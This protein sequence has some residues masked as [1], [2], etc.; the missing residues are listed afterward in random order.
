VRVGDRIALP[1]SVLAKPTGAA[2]NLDCTYCFYLSK[3]LLYDHDSQ[4]MSE[5]DLHSYLE[6]LFDSQPDGPVEVAWQGGEPTLRGLAFFRRAVEL[7]EQLHRPG[8]HVRH[9]LQTNGTLLDDKWGAFLAEHDFLVG[10]S[11]DGPLDLHDTYRVNR[12]G[13]GSHTQV[14][15]G[16]QI[17]QRHGVEANIICTV[18]AANQHHPRE[19]Y[20]YFRDILGA[21]YLQFI[22]VVERVPA[23]QL[24]LAEAGWRSEPHGARTVLYQQHGNAVTSRSANPTAYGEFLV[25]IFDEWLTRDVGAV[26]VQDFDVM[27]A[28]LFGQH[29]LCV[30]SPEC[31]NAIAVEHNGDVYSCDHYVEPDHLLGNVVRESLAS[32]VSSSQQLKFG[33]SKRTSL[34]AQCQAC[35][36][37]WACHGGCPKDRFAT[38][39]DRDPQL[40]YLCGGYYAFFTHAQPAIEEMG[41]LLRFG[42]PASDIMG[43]APLGRRGSAVGLP[44]HVT[45]AR[46]MLWDSQVGVAGCRRRTQESQDG[47]WSGDQIGRMAHEIGDDEIL[48]LR[49]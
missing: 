11:M 46:R 5:S 34:P 40:N 12:A 35:P 14:L 49:P 3:E 28:N 33:R 18:H 9:T 47:A 42:R 21:R 2:C 8:Q 44:Q 48:E 16:W 30:H 27:L 43:D 23:E 17:L 32:L 24:S 45:L 7:A 10:L 20:R 13:R 29:S 36:V 6:N 4:L 26:F 31:G 15:R 19:V 25:E 41:R 38:T 22:P 37:R 39:A 1:F